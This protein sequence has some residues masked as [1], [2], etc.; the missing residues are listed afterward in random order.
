MFQELFN[1]N[2]NDPNINFYLGRSAFEL[3]KYQESLVA[4]ERVLFEKPDSLRTQLEMARAYFLSKEYKSAKKMFQNLE[5]NPKVPGELK[6][7]IAKYLSVIDTKIPKH[8]FNGMLMAGVT[9]DSNLKNR[10]KHDSYY[11][12]L[13]NDNVTTTTLDASGWAIQEVGVFNYLYKK[14]DMEQFKNTVMIYNRD[15]RKSEY[16]SDDVTLININPIYQVKY[17]QKLNI[18]YSLFSDIMWL[19]NKKYINT[20]GVSPKIS[21]MY[22]VKNTIISTLKYQKKSYAQSENK[23]KNSV[24]KQIDGS[25][26]HNYKS[27]LIF[28]PTLTVAKERKNDNNQVVVDYDSYSLGLNTT[29][30]YRPYLLFNPSIIYKKTKYKDM[31]TSFNKKA[32]HTNMKYGIVGTYIHSTDWIFNTNLSFTKQSSNIAKDEYDKYNFGFNV[33][34][35]F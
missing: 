11:S 14:D 28:T 15:M 1:N 5:E 22:D 35:S 31:D 9:Y 12:P 18:D 30:I 23:S 29:Y 24:Y 32:K 34:R 6:Q 3:K 4:Y 10:S 25:I 27:N 7:N 2:L 17:N 19:D 21:Y 8:F 26:K 13:I 33:I 16:S 20:Y